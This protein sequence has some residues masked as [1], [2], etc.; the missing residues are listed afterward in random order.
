MTRGC[1]E[2]LES[3]LA[4][5]EAFVALFSVAV[6]STAALWSTNVH[7]TLIKTHIARLSART[8]DVVF[9]V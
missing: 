9:G 1:E 4:A 8:T 2:S 7:K 6:T 3:R 5:M